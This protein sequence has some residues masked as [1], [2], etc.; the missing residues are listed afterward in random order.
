MLLVIVTLVSPIVKFPVF[1]KYLCLFDDAKLFRHADNFWQSQKHLGIIYQFTPIVNVSVILLIISSEFG[2]PA[3]FRVSLI[4]LFLTII[5]K[6]FSLGDRCRGRQA[7][8]AVLGG[9]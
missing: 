9:R 7:Q 6:L 1:H 2:T 5:R 8:A 3:Y 4:G